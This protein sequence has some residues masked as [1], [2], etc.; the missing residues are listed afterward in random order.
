MISEKQYFLDTYVQTA[1]VSNAVQTQLTNLQTQITTNEKLT[2]DVTT[3][4]VASNGNIVI[5]DNSSCVHIFIFAV[6]VTSY[7]IQL[8]ATLDPDSSINIK[9]GFDCTN[10]TQEIQISVIDSLNQP[11]GDGIFFPEIGKITHADVLYS[12]TPE[13]RSILYNQ[14]PD[15]NQL[16]SELLDVE[17]TNIQDSDSIYFDS[18]S[19]KWIN[20]SISPNIQTALNL[21]E[22]LV[23]AGTTTQYYRGDKTFQTLDK[24]AVGLN[25]V[26]NTSDINKPIS[27]ATQTALN[28]KANIVTTYSKTETDNL[29]EDANPLVQRDWWV[30]TR[31]LVDA[32][33]N[34][35]A[36][37]EITS[38]IAGIAPSGVTITTTNN[39]DQG[40]YNPLIYDSINNVIKVDP[41]L[42]DNYNFKI[43]LRLNVRRQI[44]GTGTFRLELRRPD[45]INLID[46]ANLNFP[47]STSI[48]NTQPIPEDLIIYT[49]TDSGG[50]DSFQTQGFKLF[51]RS[52]VTTS[53]ILTFSSAD[54][55]PTNPYN[56]QMFLIK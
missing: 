32:V 34:S 44:S 41:S 14:T 23:T 4:N 18:I 28:L 10:L 29:I 24:I 12:N 22:N 36:G 2:L 17:F 54:G 56:L 50:A 53:D 3:S 9:L 8:T 1:P 51:I 20:G 27:T 42:T 19:N 40:I 38:L 13:S 48:P 47:A 7:T 49:R 46:V 37:V 35:T 15:F 31:N 25:N 26:D 16:L 39:V 5:N 11:I 21:K 30:G 52:I 45:G 6:G 55:T 33:I 43:F